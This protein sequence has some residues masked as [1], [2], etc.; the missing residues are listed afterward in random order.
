[1]DFNKFL[2]SR[3]GNSIERFESIKVQSEL[4]PLLKV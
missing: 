2:I 3:D 4:K 1:M